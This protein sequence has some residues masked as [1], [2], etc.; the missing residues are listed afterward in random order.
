MKY[1]AE[2]GYRHDRQAKL[3]VLVTNLGTP[4]A[5]T[6]KAL[7]SYLAEF[8]WD[9]RIVEPP[10]PRAVWWMIL[11]GIILRVR[12]QVKAHDYETI[13]GKFGDASPL[14][15][16]TK[17]QAK[18]IAERLVSRLSPSVEVEVAMRYGNPSM[19][20]GLD[21]LRQK[22]CERLI[23]LPLY[24]QYS[25]ATTGSTW[26]AL[27]DA[28]KAWRRIPDVRFISH[29]HR[30]TGYIQALAKSV[31]DYWA[32][33]GKPDKLLMSFHGIPQRYLDQGD[34]YHCECHVTGRL[35]AEALGLTKDE[36]VLSFQSLFGKEEWI[37]PYTDVTIKGLPALGVKN[38][39][40]ICPGF[41]ADCLETIEEIDVENR[42]YFMEAGGESFHYIPAL[43]W[44][45]DHLD[46]LADVVLSNAQD[47]VNV[48]EDTQEAL[49]ERQAI[50]A[51]AQAMGCPF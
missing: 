25:A 33:H 9:P 26:D 6:K 48:S 42:G 28:L 38:L 45:D 23:V 30:H 34:A 43:N 2:Q 44:R 19:A 7:T 41:S 36:Y 4:D 8:L 20:A 16:I 40:V 10:P 21:A 1:T 47:W 13:W 18:G 46:A 50:R 3:G 49:A 12:P 15:D 35:L 5:P 51:R 32:E 31:Q 37:K 22:G 39:H 17:A 27:A 14:L 24:P 11:H 29:Y